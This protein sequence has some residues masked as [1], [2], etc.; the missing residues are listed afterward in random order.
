MYN[1]TFKAYCFVSGGR[2]HWYSKGLTY[3]L[4]WLFNKTQKS[5][6]VYVN[7]MNFKSLRFLKLHTL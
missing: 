4:S 1:K 6:R 3:M 7:N 5:N 2:T